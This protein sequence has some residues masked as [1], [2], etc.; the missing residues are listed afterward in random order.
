MTK[1]IAAF[2]Q[3]KGMSFQKP[4]HSLTADF[5]R[6]VGS[7]VLLCDQLSHINIETIYLN[8]NLSNNDNEQVLI[9]MEANRSKQ[10]DP[11]N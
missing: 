5:I 4:R 10:T 7:I 3:G 1:S 8:T 11:S 6:N 9:R 2:T